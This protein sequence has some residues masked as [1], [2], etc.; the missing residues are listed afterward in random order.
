VSRH[1]NDCCA[2][3]ATFWGIAT[4]LTVMLLAFGPGVLCLFAAR[5]QRLQ[6]RPTAGTEAPS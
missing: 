2:P 4:G 1:R 3:F 6:P 5:L